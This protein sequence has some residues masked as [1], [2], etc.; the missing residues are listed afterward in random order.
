[1]IRKIYNWIIRFMGRDC[2]VKIPT[3]EMLKAKREYEELAR[4]Y[5]AK[6]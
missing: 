4:K 5:P 1:M 2:G 3:Q 6:K